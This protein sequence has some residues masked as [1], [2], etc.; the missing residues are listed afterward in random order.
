MVTDRYGVGNQL[1]IANVSTGEIMSILSA[2]PDGQEI[3]HIN[4][5]PDGDGLVAASGSTLWIM[6]PPG[7]LILWEKEGDSF[8]E[9]FRTET[10][11]ASADPSRRKLSLF[12]PTAQFVALQ[13]MLK[14]E[15]GNEVIL[16]YDRESRKT[17]LEKRDYDGPVVVR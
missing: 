15:A 3:S 14:P 16:I 13:Q 9:V 12:S 11:Q 8:I 17:I 7:M 4:W 10:V 1:Y 5:A 2:Y 6:E